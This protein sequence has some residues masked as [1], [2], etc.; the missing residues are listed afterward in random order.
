MATNINVQFVKS[1]MTH[2]AT[3]F[4]A[5][6]LTNAIVG[7]VN[8]SDCDSDS[9]VNNN[10]NINNNKN[11]IEPNNNNIDLPKHMLMRLEKKYHA[12][13]ST[14][15]SGQNQIK[16]VTFQKVTSQTTSHVKKD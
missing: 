13:N 5:K 12:Q 16:M 9:T 4:S 14:G 1:M 7:A 2:R 15:K 8:N 6:N 10:N 3:C 11:I